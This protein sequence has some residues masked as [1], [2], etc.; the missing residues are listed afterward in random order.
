MDYLNSIQ[1][2]K[3]PFADSSGDDLYLSQPVREG[4]EKITHSIRLGAGLHVVVGSKGSGKTTLCG[5]LS[6]KF[7]A[8]KNTIVLTINNPQYSN[9]QQFLTALAGPFKT[10]KVPSGI[11]DN[12]F[13]EA[14]NTFFHKQC[15]QEKK[16][17]LLLIDNGQTL[18][19]FCL[20]ALNTLYEHHTDCRRMLQTVI[21]GE[22]SLQKKIKS[23][24]EV[25][26]RVVFTIPLKSFSFKESKELIRFHLERAAA[27]PDSP[28][29]LFNTLSQWAIYRLTQ[30]NPKQIIDLC[31]LIV[32]TL[33]IE[34]KKEANWFM[35]LR[36]ANLLIPKRAKKLQ[37]IRTGTL[38]SLIVLMLVFGMVSEQMKTTMAPPA[39]KPARPP[40]TK[41]A[42]PLKPQPQKVAK[43]EEAVQP[44]PEAAEES[45]VSPSAETGITAIIEKAA[46][47]QPE[48]PEE[49]A[50]IPQPAEEEIAVVPPPADQGAVTEE[51]AQERTATAKIPVPAEPAIET[52]PVAPEPEQV[53]EITKII[54]PAIKERRKVVPGDTFLVM[55]QK[56]YGPGHLKPHFINQVIAANPQLRN[57][58][59]LAVG[60]D[61]FFPVLAAKDE[62]IFDVMAEKPVDEVKKTGSLV[63]KKLDRELQPADSPDLLGKL[64]VQPGETLGKLIR[65]IYGPF[66]FNKDYTNKV[67]AVNPQLRSPDHLEV[68]ETIYFPDLPVAA[69]IGLPAKPQPIASRGETPEFLGEITAI[70]GETFGDMIRRIYGPYSFNNK[71]VKKVLLVNPDMKSA[72][73]LSIG[74]KVRFPT[75]LVALTPKAEDVWWVK[76]ISLDNLQS[77]YRY[78]RV[79]SK[80]SPPMLIIPSRDKAGR[81]IFNVLLQ[82]YFMDKQS[83]QT[84]LNDLPDSITAD[85]KI[86]HG[87]DSNTYYYW[88]KPEK[89]NDSKQR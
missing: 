52:L 67:L 19:D 18:P 47:Q 34:N 88:T 28:P 2:K 64:T 79:Y 33:I 62:R 61:V 6:E 1:C 81:V 10:I 8:D 15:L 32:I 9:L 29:V 35:T 43:V 49:G 11:D 65:G 50:A 48:I 77:A 60:D 4:F 39:K 26:S 17:V 69:E 85:A 71:N 72:N 37:L 75:I 76:I 31:H 25:N 36:C 13:Q 83:A 70:E 20:Q 44:E 30:G 23:I 89:S 59:N 82:K 78:L 22:P 45:A 46:Q 57:P 40:V 51:P 12:K 86:L 3:E 38:S 68:G 41:K 16:N 84:A 54:S 58:E 5:Q 87:L 7:S 42:L 14:F 27:N 56:V 55:I 73:S 24:S 53:V 80:W 63:S 66:S 21:C 74:Q